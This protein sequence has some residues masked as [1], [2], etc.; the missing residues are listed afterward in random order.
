[1][2]RNMSVRTLGRSLPWETIIPAS[3]FA[4]AAACWYSP[5]FAP[6]IAFVI[7]GFGA[8]FFDS[9]AA[10]FTKPA[11]LGLSVALT[12]SFQTFA[13]EENSEQTD[14]LLDALADSIGRALQSSALT[15]TIKASIM[16]TLKDDDLQRATIHTLQSALIKASE[17]EGFRETAMDVTKRAF[18]GALSNKDYV[19][20]LMTSIVSAIVSASQN[21]ELTKSLLGVVTQA[22]SEALADEDF[23]SE[24]RGAVKDC[25]RD[26]DLYRAGAKGM[27]SAAFGRKGSNEATEGEKS[28]SQARLSRGHLSLDPAKK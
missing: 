7:L 8:V 4:A 17:N 6:S 24:I 1:M 16:D 12:D 11:V 14:R 5:E 28:T 10:Y 13:A 26:G 18:V 21:E 27:I 2:K 25:L 19:D 23:V 15:S 9:F 20:E 3:F 22:V